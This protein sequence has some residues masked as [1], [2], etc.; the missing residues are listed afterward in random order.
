MRPSIPSTVILVMALTGSSPTGG[1][2]AGVF[3][4]GMR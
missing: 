2:G 4:Y 3:V 1:G